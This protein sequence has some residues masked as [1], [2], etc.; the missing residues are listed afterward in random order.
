MTI[1]QTAPPPRFSILL[2]THNR[3]DVL[4]FAI[5]SVLAQTVQDFELLI[6]GDGCTD[7]T[8]AVVAGFPDNRIHWFDLPKGPAFGYANRNLALRA[9]RGEFIAYM[10]HD[11]LW[12][13]DHLAT[14]E[15]HLANPA[16]ELAYSRTIWAAP[17]GTITPAAFNLHDEATRRAFIAM[18]ANNISATNV[19]HRRS[20][21]QKYG[22]WD[23][24]LP[25]NG[26][27][28]LW[29]RII[30]GGGGNNF[31]YEPSPTGLHFRAV[32]KTEATLGPPDLYHWREL[33]ARGIFSDTI[34]T[35]PTASDEPEQ[36][37]AWRALQ[38][39]PTG[40]M[41][42]LRAEVHEALDRC[43]GRVDL[44][45]VSQQQTPYIAHLEQ[46]VALKDQHIANIEAFVRVKDQHIANI[47][48][49]S[50]TKDQHIANLEQ[51]IASKDQTI[52]Q[53]A[54]HST[55]LE[56]VIAEQRTHVTQL[57]DYVATLTQRLNT[58]EEHFAI[59]GQQLQRA[60]HDLADKERHIARFERW[61]PVRFYRRLRALGR[62]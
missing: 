24:S 9:A 42:R 36:A 57:E 26:D 15:A 4:P 30:K 35:V 28:E 18:E 34:P 59:Q 27:W 60:E 3:A 52:A 1:R 21:L 51:F 31:A 19:A 14:L 10:P 2:P 44:I 17:D 46:T 33:R 12:F 23:E 50:R 43:A 29:A 55:N 38:A 20:C 45:A 47:E 62:R 16:I 13:P 53:Q 25:R 8:D 58:A 5:S 7:Q 56:Q 11:D 49:F 48:E 32:W 6:V 40:E 41:R 54:Q 39:A 37:T 61:L 22:Y